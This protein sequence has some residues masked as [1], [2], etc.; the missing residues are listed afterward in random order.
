[1]AS[2]AEQLA[3]NLNFGA[4]AKAEELKKRIWF[5]LA[6]LLVY[7]LGTFI[8]IPG[9][10]PTAFAAAFNTQSGLMGMINMF[11]GGAIERMAIFALNIMPYISAS[12]IMQLM[13]SVVP[14]LETLKK[15]GEHGRKQLNQ[16][17]RYLTV[18][19][20][21]FQAFGIAYGL[22]LQTSGAAGPIVTDP[23][24]F[25]VITTVVS[26]V[27][28]TLFLMWLGEQIT[29]RGVGNG[30]SLIIMAGI[31]AGLPSA[32]VQ[33]LELARQSVLSW[34]MVLLLVVVMLAVVAAIVF[35]ERAQRRL[36]VQYPKRQMGNRMFQG[37]ASHLPLKLN[38]SGVI[39]PIFASSLL[40]LPGAAGSFLQNAGPGWEWL[41]ATVA[42]LGH[43]QPLWFATYVALILF[44]AFFYTSIVLNPQ[45]TADNLRKYGGFLP[46]IRPGAKTAEY[47]DYVLTRITVVGAL[48]LAAVCVLPE[49]LQS[50]ARVSF[51][52]GGTSLLIA[53]SV[54]MDTVAQIQSHLLAHQ[55]EGLIKKAKLRGATRR[56]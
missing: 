25:F 31:V 52:F 50:Y 47:I 55:Y 56:I 7:R 35:I 24:P 53:V 1:M 54:T 30:T 27:G 44:F 43:G 19:L 17:T 36:L 3:A 29:A 5:T 45:E 12:I 10:N 22:Q 13:Q 11:S 14:S 51:Y 16:Y 38:A 49:M 28:G 37:D 46:G 39:P 40:M 15:E 48:Y 8:P 4:F 41:G 23:G 42:A 18:A 6:A 32:I 21:A 33:T 34:G 9:I 20:A 26:L 2:A